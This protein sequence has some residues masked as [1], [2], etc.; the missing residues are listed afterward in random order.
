MSRLK[1]SLAITGAA[2][3]SLGLA[4][5]APTSPASPDIEAGH[6]P[7]LESGQHDGTYTTPA[8]ERAA[9]FGASLL[10][11][12]ETKC[13]RPGDGEHVTAQRL[14]NSVVSLVLERD[15][16][17]TV[18]DAHQGSY[19]VSVSAGYGP[20]GVR[21]DKIVDFSV[22]AFA[23]KTPVYRLVGTDVTTG[24]VIS[25]T[26]RLPGL[27]SMVVGNTGASLSDEYTRQL[28]ND[29]A[30]VVGQENRGEPTRMVSAG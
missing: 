23:D 30:V 15:V 13:L 28:L 5:L 14:G 27:P 6:C 3:L 11:F 9:L 22:A 12:L 10:G 7:A 19:R 18:P 26:Q 8:S 2:G 29:A 24:F 4:S 21:L 20:Q 17:T 25:E 1:R 16:A